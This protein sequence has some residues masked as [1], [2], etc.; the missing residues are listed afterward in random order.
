M[1]EPIGGCIWLGRALNKHRI[2]TGLAQFGKHH[3]FLTTYLIANFAYRV[4]AGSRISSKL[5]FM[6]FIYFSIDRNN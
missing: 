6:L 2:V 1:A 4:R 3:S 5:F